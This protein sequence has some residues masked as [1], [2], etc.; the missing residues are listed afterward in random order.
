MTDS[1]DASPFRIVNGRVLAPDGDLVTADISVEGG[2]IGA[3]GGGGGRGPV[4]DAMGALVLP[5]LVD[6]HG[7]A[8]E[9]QMM[10]RPGVQFAIDLALLDSDRQLVANGITTAFHAITCSWE[11]GLRC[12]DNA[13]ALIDSIR[14]LR[15]R[16]ACDTRVHLRHEAFNLEAVDDLLG[17][18]AAGTVDLVAFNDHTPGIARHLA[19]PQKL[20]KFAERAGMGIQDFAAL[21]ERIASRDGEV[22]DAT[23]RI[24]AAAVAA[25][26]VMA[27][28]DDPSPETRDGFHGLGARLCEFPFSLE[29]AERA[30]ALGD[31]VLMGAPNVVRGGSHINLVSAAALVAA[32]ICSVLTSDYYYPALLQA[33][34][35]L[36]RDGVMPFGEAWALVS[37]NP[38]RAVGLVDRGQIAPGQRADLVL[39]DAAETPARPVATLVGG[40]VVHAA[41]RLSA[42]GFSAAA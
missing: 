31:V 3:V 21:L 28:H 37:R 41:G 14:R 34:F 16:L 2:R 9:R 19:T 30:R 23:R 20:A 24:A 42:A 6:L 22:A 4:L 10:P 27:S 5:G 38:A 25:G 33:P 35:R 15:P 8:F 1:A 39:V 26:V 17:W 12:R 7:D 11:P 13:S 36:A 29:T 40:R 18:I 32:R